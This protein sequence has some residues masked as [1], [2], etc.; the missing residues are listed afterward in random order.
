[1]WDIVDTPRAD[2][3][4][5]IIASPS[6]VN[7]IAIGSDGRTF[8]AVDIPNSHVHKSTDGGVTWTVDLAGTAGTL[9]T[10]GANLP[11][12]N[13]AVAP[14]D[15]NFLVA[16]TDGGGPPGPRMVFASLDGGANWE[17]TSIVL[18]G[19][20][21][22]ISCVDISVTYGGNNRDIAVGTRTGSGGGGVYA[23][24]KRPGISTGWQNQSLPASDVVALKFSPTYPSDSSLV[25]VSSG[26]GTFLRVG[27]RDT[28]ASPPST[29]WTS[30]YG[31]TPPE[32]S[33]AGAGTSP[34]STEII[35]A[36]LELPSDFSG[37]DPALRRIY[38][39]TDAVAGP[40]SG[41][42][43]IDITGVNRI[44]PPITAAGRISSIAYW[45]TYAEGI[46]LAGEVTGGALAPTPSSNGVYIWRTS[47]PNVTVGTPT[48]LP[49]DARRSPT[50]GA[51]SGLA[52]AQVAW[53]PDGGRAYCG[54]SSACLGAFVAPSGAVNCSTWPDGY[55]NWV[56]LDESAFSV[57]PYTP[58]YDQLLV[59]FS[60]AQD[61]VIGNIWNQ[62]SLIDTEI[63]LLSDV[64]ALEAPEVGGGA[65]A[66]QDYD[67]LY[68]FSISDNLTVPISFD[69]VWRSTSVPLGQ[70]WERVLCL[71]TSDTG[72]ILRIKQTSY[73]ETDRSE[74]IAFADRGTDVVGYS[75]N[76]GQVW[77]VRFLTTVTDLALATDDTMYILNDITVYRYAREGSNWIQTDKE[78]TQLDAGHTI[79][80]PQK[81]PGGEGETTGD[82][83]IV[84]EAGLPYGRG[85]VAYADFA[86]AIVDFEPPI[87]GRVEPPIQGSAHVIADDKFDQNKT[88]YNAVHDEFAGVSGKIYRWVIDKS[89][90]WDELE[91]PNSAFYGVA[92]RNDVLYGAWRTAEISEIFAYTAGA[93]RTL[94]PRVNVPPPPEWDYLTEG[95]TALVIFTREPSSL[96]ISSNEDNSLWAI[97]N[98]DYDWTSKVGCLWSYVDTVAKVGPWTTSPASGDFISVDPVSGRAI[99][100]NFKWRQLSYALAYELQ[101]AKGSDFSIVVLRN[102]YIVPVNPLSPE[103]Y[104]PA[105]GLVPTPRSGIAS[106]GNLE[107]GHTYYWR[108]RARTTVTGEATRSPWSATMYFTVGAGFPVTSPYPTLNLF[109]P[110]YGARGVSRSPGFSW[111][112]MPRT[113][114]Y[115]FV[116]AQDTALQQVVVKT[117]VSQT[118]YL[119]DGELDFNTSYFWQV[120][121]ID[122]VVSDPSPIGTFT[123][124][125]EQKPV[126]PI[127]EQPAP[128]PSWVWWIIAVFTALV[129]V[130]IAFTMVK[131]SYTRPGGGKLFKVEPIVDKP[132]KPMLKSRIAKIWESITMAVRRQRYLRK[133]GAGESEVSKSEDSQD[134][135]T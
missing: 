49:S 105:G 11:V 134:K 77:N 114:K 19:A 83:V 78:A 89:T 27:I 92:Q 67:V 129:V 40:Q 20:G 64:A 31:A 42:Y 100:V 45:G 44:N 75:G 66:F 48:W 127:T 12:W 104:F 73:E 41:V 80:V 25:A 112:P 34:I 87:S 24:V 3:T 15:V 110:T 56:A 99:E 68:L 88:I 39:S 60:K 97:D 131:P 17:N 71:A 128:I 26:T 126:A 98:R 62:I 118:A 51:G 76:E 55:L 32:I 120:R 4:T 123:V 91:P 109:S 36:D 5:N 53:S 21:E 90:K 37:Q 95:L 130:I 69:S 93:D 82:W 57:S 116:L 7:I 33:T 59:S 103:V 13:L 74:A 2:N 122:P 117:T 111:S 125:A 28:A 35:T 72:T 124:V 38:V 16:V 85:R 61:T 113:T 108:V 121:A 96:K 79:A 47:N 29:D 1:M 63:S 23:I 46:L 18:G 107:A 58:A 84:G 106:F 133:R 94:Y 119:Y 115:E 6:E 101:L 102:E 54:T 8:Y 65:E 132:E 135:L 86:Q 22:Y 70:T 52:N 9:I 10:A 14:D 30:I 50:G 81:N 43:R